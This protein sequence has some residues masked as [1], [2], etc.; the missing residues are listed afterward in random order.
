MSRV[1]YVDGQYVPHRIAAVHIEDRGYQFADG[2]YEVLAVVGEHIVD[3][4]PH[5]IRLARSL[6]EL[7]IAAPMPD[8]ALKIVLRKVI[9]RNRVRIDSDPVGS[10]VHGSLSR[11]LREANLARAAAA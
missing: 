1:A 8:M 9:R 7:R 4:E 2:V 11:R 6:S 5:L 3:E 10:G